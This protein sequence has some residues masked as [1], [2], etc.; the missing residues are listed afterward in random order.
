MR[1]LPTVVTAGI[2][3]VFAAIAV[4][5]IFDGSD[6]E[7]QTGVQPTIGPTP[8]PICRII[9]GDEVCVGVGEP[10]C[11]PTTQVVPFFDQLVL[12]REIPE[13]LA[14]SE[15]CATNC[16]EGQPCNNPAEI[17]YKSADGGAHF[18]VSTAT[19][20]AVEPRGRE[21]IQLGSIPGYITR[22]EGTTGTTVYGV[23]FELRGRAYTVIAILGPNNRLTEAD[24]NAMALDMA[25][26]G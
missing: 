11:L 20:L 8:S 17:K 18:Q 24:L 10:F 1:P 26:Q 14:F 16:A 3:L 15:A 25:M 23:E 13:G 4:A 21:S 6:P 12:P 22:N 9:D 5:T 7:P 2:V 19:G